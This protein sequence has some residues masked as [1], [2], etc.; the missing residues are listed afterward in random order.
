MLKCVSKFGKVKVVTDN[1][2]Y[3]VVLWITISEKMWWKFEN[4]K[5]DN[6]ISQRG[7]ET[8]WLDAQLLYINI[9]KS[10]YE[11]RSNQKLK[12]SFLNYYVGPRFLEG[13]AISN[14]RIRLSSEFSSS[15]NA[16]SLSNLS[17]SNWYLR[18]RRWKSLVIIRLLAD[19]YS[20]FWRVTK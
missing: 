10:N 12:S 7:R 5:H 19:V 16:R 14:W 8:F 11:L 4:L 6:I 17:M 2:C 18:A 20:K 13:I 1:L 3:E 15:F 9:N